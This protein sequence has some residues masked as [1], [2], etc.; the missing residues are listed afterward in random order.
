MSAESEVEGAM[1]L[2]P[3]IH[4]TVS[5]VMWLIGAYNK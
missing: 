1:A 5:F 4:E 2:F 3:E